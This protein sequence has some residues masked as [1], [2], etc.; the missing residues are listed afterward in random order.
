MITSLSKC[1]RRRRGD[2]RRSPNGLIDTIFMPAIAYFKDKGDGRWINLVWYFKREQS[3][4]ADLTDD[5]V[6]YVLS[7]LVCLPVIDTHAEFVLA[8][9]ARKNPE[10]VFDFFAGRL[11]FAESREKDSEERYQA[12]PHRLYE[13]HKAFAGIAQHAVRCARKSFHSGDGMFRFRE[14]R[15]LAASFP[16]YGEAYQRVLDLYVQ[17]GSRED[18]EF[19]AQVMSSYHGEVSLNRTCKSLVRALPPD[20]PLLSDV[21][22]VLQNMGV[23]SG[24]FGMV[25]AYQAK[26]EEMTRWLDDADDKIRG[27]ANSYIRLLDRQIAA[28][29]RRSE[30]SLEM[31]KRMYCDPGDGED[32]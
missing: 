26:K 32:A 30:E 10:K 19:V 28:E 15:L 31:R 1:S 9:L 6:D 13:L 16:D 12:V 7:S 20:D 24:E 17:C 27:F 21:E 3:F 8:I 18:I 23:V 22:V 5:Q 2:I 29:Q 4:L 14:G 11:K 25:Q